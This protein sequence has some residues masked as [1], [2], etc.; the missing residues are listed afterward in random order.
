MC[1]TL[2]LAAALAYASFQLEKYLSEP[3]SISCILGNTT[4]PESS[5]EKLNK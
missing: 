3:S 2:L 5:V 4:A 1:N